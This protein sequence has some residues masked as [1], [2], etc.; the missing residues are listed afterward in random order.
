M[1]FTEN[2]PVVTNDTHQPQKYP[3]HQKQLLGQTCMCDIALKLPQY[4]HLLTE[5]TLVPIWSLASWF[6]VQSPYYQV[7][8]QPENTY[9]C[10][11]KVTGQVWESQ[12]KDKHQLLLHHCK[13][14]SVNNVVN[15][16]KLMLC[17]CHSM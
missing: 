3:H 6:Q 15:I 5:N 17:L 2:S 11:L 16:L 14:H 10:I 12:K 1:T 4:F 9:S 13:V 7:T 8:V